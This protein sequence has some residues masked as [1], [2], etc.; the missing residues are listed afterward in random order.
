MKFDTVQWKKTKL[1]DVVTHVK[2]QV[3]PE[4]S[5]LQYYV[6]GEHFSSDDIDL[7]GKGLLEGSTIGPAFTMRFKPGQVLLMSR[8]PNLRKMAVADFKGICS[9]VTYVLETKSKLLLQ[10]YLPFIMQTNDFWDF[11]V[12]NQRGS[13]NPYLNWSD[14]EKYEFLLPPVKEQRN[15]SELLWSS[16]HTQRAYNQVIKHADA[17]ITSIRE[18]II[19]QATETTTLDQYIVAINA[20][21]SVRGQSTP[22]KNGTYGVLK[23]SAV[24]DDHFQPNENKQLVSEK[25]FQERFSVQKD[26]F[27]ITRCNTTELVGRVVLVD[28]DYPQ[29]M[30]CDKTLELVIDETR[31][32]KPYLLEVLRSESIKRQIRMHAT[33][34][35]GAMKNISQKEIRSLTIP[36]LDPFK[37]RQFADRFAQIKAMKA[38]AEEAL[39]SLRRVHSSLLNQVLRGA[40]NV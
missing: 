15:I 19:A 14:F 22:A 1:G 34:T 23:V 24:T 20:G 39:S 13:T 30:L 33:G 11:G 6:A 21:K 10:E 32:C 29:L 18:E 4:E 37:Q 27:L 8:R 38:Q 12:S 17:L 31:A 9:N 28:Q 16:H 2:D 35:G 36:D 40:L 3:R 7:N 5:S 25:D 26:A